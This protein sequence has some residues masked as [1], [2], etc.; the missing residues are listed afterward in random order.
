M[1]NLKNKIN[2]QTKQNRNRL[3]DT[4]NKQAAVRRQAGWELVKKV[5]GIKRQN[6]QLKKQMNHGDTE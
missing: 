2:E 1:W 5:K 4:E 6:L 3:V